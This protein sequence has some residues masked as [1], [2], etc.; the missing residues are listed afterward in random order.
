M[1]NVWTCGGTRWSCS[2]GPDVPAQTVLLR[3]S[4][5]AAQAEPELE[6]FGTLE[7]MLRIQ[8]RLN[9]TTVNTHTQRRRHTHPHTHTFRH[10]RADTRGSMQPGLP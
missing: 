4:P 3:L 10:T 6:E 7:E 2:P 1:S 5:P 9:K 8:N